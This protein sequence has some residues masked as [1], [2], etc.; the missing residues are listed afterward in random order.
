MFV[1]DITAKLSPISPSGY[2]I[3]GHEREKFTS[4]HNIEVE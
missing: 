3:N 4:N 2:D 1:N